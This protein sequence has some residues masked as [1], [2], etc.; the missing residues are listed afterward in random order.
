MPADVAWHVAGILIVSFTAHAALRLTGLDPLGP[1]LGDGENAESS[2]LPRA[3]RQGF[4]GAH[5]EQRTPST[6][7]F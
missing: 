4:G 3:Q 7:R 2:R 1:L 6:P 5:P